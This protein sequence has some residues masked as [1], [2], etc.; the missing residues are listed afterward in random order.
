MWGGCIFQFLPVFLWLLWP[1]FSISLLELSSFSCSL[2]IAVSQIM[3]VVKW[4]VASRI[5]R[6]HPRLL[7]PGVHA[8][9][10]PSDCGEYGF[11]PGMRVCYMTQLTYKKGDYPGEP[12]QITWAFWEQNIFLRLVPGEVRE[13]HSGSPE[14]KQTFIRFM[15]CLLRRMTFRSWKQSSAHR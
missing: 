8:L 11:Y 5:L 9:H 7:F 13:M 1:I 2:D 12:N 4:C 6:W 15:N 14:K 3:V 10:N